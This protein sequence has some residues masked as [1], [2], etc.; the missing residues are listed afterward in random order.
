MHQRRIA[1]D[2]VDPDGAR[3]I[4]NGARKLD[5]VA[6]RAF[7]DHGYRRDGNSLVGDANAEFVTDAIDSFNQTI[8]VAMNLVDYSRGG[9]FDGFAG[10]VAQTEAQRDGANVE[11][12][13]LRHRDRLED[14]CLRV[15]HFSIQI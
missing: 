11:M 2:E 10:A 8:C 13:H 3:R 4:V 9:A 5:R 1:A 6:G 15:F 14:F 12:F 7:D